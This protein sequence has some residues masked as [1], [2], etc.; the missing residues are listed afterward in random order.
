MMVRVPEKQVP[1]VTLPW[2]HVP[3]VYWPS[4]LAPFSQPSVTCPLITAVKP[5]CTTWT[6]AVRPGRRQT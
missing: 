3:W 1:P 2:S 4:T 5:V 6:G